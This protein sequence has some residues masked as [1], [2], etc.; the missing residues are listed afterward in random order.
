MVLGPHVKVVH[1]KDTLINRPCNGIGPAQCHGELGSGKGLRGVASRGM[2]ASK[3]EYQNA[4]TD[5]MAGST[6]VDV[7][8]GG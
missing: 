1:P 4:Q 5:E 2:K 3:W 7:V 6:E 8:K